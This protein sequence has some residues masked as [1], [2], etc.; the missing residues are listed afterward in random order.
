[1]LVSSV[2]Y[3]QKEAAFMNAFQTI[4]FPI[5]YLFWKFLRNC[6]YAWAHSKKHNQIQCHLPTTR[7]NLTLNSIHLNNFAIWYECNAHSLHW[8]HS[9]NSWKQRAAAIFTHELIWLGVI[10]GFKC[11]IRAYL[12]QLFQ[13]GEKLFCSFE[14]PNLRVQISHRR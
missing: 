1:M 2:Y 12:F 10:L 5:L 4:L 11:E 8:R 13:I 6:F 9:F 7:L 3:S 14:Y